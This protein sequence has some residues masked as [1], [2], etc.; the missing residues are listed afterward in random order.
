VPEVA[1]PLPGRVLFDQEWT[2]LAF[3]HWSVDPDVVAPLLPAGV[4]PDV[5][6]GVTYVGL[7]P[8]HMRR[9]GPGRGHAA[10]YFGDFLETNVRLYGVDAEGHHGVVFRSLEASRL[11]TVLVARWGYRL[12]YMWARMHVERTGDVWVWTSRRRWPGSGWSTRI[13]IEVGQEVTDP[14]A[15][16]LWLTSRWGLHHELAGRTVWTP[17]A[18]GA[19]PL[20]EARVL[21]LSDE[22]VAA[23]GLP[24]DGL[25]TVPARF[26]H[27]VHTVF[28]WPRRLPA[29]VGARA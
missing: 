25:P 7:I 20:R 29:G 23:A 3:L 13:A 4:Q 12:P 24:V 8:F 27:G 26:S 5:V 21:E 2:D 18:H 1:P 14:T 17:N 28:G 6:D 16:D 19:W 11:G 10:P 9:A 15:L 22:L